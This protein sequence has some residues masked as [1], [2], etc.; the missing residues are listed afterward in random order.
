[1]SGGAAIADAS[2]S[3][4]ADGAGLRADHR[5]SGA[6]SVW[7]ADRELSGAGAVGGVERRSA[8]AGT[9]QQAR[10]LAAALLAGGSGASD[11]AQ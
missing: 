4:F 11:G 3:G 9:H 8:T 7:Q 5:E 2:W 6:V 1:M 10:Q